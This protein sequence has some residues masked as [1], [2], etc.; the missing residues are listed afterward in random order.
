[1]KLKTTV[2][3]IYPMIRSWLASLIEEGVSARSVNRKL[4]SL[5]T[6]FKYLLR[7]G[8]IETNPVR[9]LVSLQDS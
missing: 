2:Q 7:L 9:Y 6:Y 5:K 1:M 4:S 3:V 8:L